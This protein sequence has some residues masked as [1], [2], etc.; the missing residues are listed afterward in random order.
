MFQQHFRVGER[1]PAYA[2]KNDLTHIEYNSAGFQLFMIFNGIDEEEDSQVKVSAPFEIRF[3]EKEGIGFFTFHF[4][5]LNVIDVPFVASLLGDVDIPSLSVSEGFS[6]VVT[7]FEGSTGELR[8]LRL[9]GLGHDFSVHVAKWMEK[10]R[11][12]YL[13]DAEQEARIERVYQRYSPADLWLQSKDCAYRLEPT[14]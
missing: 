11:H 7:F 3:I 6:L 14:M 13:S 4:G 5:S 10:N 12:I 8:S 2:I 9:I 1:Y